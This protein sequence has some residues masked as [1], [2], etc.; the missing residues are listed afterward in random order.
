MGAVSKR[1][2]DISFIARANARSISCLMQGLFSLLEAAKPSTSL[3]AGRTGVKQWLQNS[4]I[5]ESGQLIKD[6][7]G[8]GFKKVFD[9]KGMMF[10]ERGG[11]QIRLA[12]S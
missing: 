3:G 9:G 10:F 11:M 4:G 12:P 1:N 6:I 7:E 8:V 2:W 5:L